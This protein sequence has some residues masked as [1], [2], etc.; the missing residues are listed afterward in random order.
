MARLLINVTLSVHHVS[1]WSEDSYETVKASYFYAQTHATSFLAK[2][3]IK[4][5]YG[6]AKPAI[7]ALRE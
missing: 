6:T 4:V 1:Q 3:P 7:L 5:N 2:P